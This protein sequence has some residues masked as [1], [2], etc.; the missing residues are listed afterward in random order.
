MAALTSA[1]VSSGAVGQD[2]TFDQTADPALVNVINTC[3][4]QPDDIQECLDVASRDCLETPGNDTTFGMSACTSNSYLAWDKVLNDR[5]AALREKV[6][7]KIFETLRDAQ[8]AWITYRD[9][10]CSLAGKAFEGGTLEPLLVT[11]C[12]E[13]KTALRVI[14][15]DQMLEDWSETY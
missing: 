7:S 2:L 15:L 9:A 12:Y 13:Y 1:A 4:A 8:R 5:Y 3:I 6:P 10:D 11:S 14:D